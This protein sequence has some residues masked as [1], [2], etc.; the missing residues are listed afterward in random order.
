MN[1]FEISLY[2][3][4]VLVASSREWQC[5]QGMRPR[6]PEAYL[7]STLRKPK[8]ANVSRYGHFQLRSRGGVNDADY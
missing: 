1:P 4:Q 6:L 5:I 8:E 2:H 3:L 7:Q